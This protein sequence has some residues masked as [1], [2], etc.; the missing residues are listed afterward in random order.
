MIT[1]ARTLCLGTMSSGNPQTDD[2]IP[3]TGHTGTSY[4]KWSTCKTVPQDKISRIYHNIHYYVKTN[5]QWEL[6]CVSQHL[7]NSKVCTGCPDRHWRIVVDC[8]V[9]MLWHAM[10]QS[11]M[12]F[13]FHRK[14]WHICGYSQFCRKHDRSN[15]ANF[16]ISEDLVQMWS[17]QV[18]EK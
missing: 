15:G 10:R 11:T 2:V 5:M 9:M 4:N 14:R 16:Q 7:L 1:V 13:P 17:K 12:S 18:L 8:G 3:Q 6:K